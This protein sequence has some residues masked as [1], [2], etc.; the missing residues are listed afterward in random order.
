MIKKTARRCRT[1]AGPYVW[2]GP[3]GHIA[4]LAASFQEAQMT[5]DLKYLVLTAMLTAA[6]WIPYI[7]CQVRPT[8]RSSR[9]IMPI[10]LCRGRC[11]HG[12][13]VRTAP[14]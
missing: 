14:T 13:S 10:L 3:T 12:A 4:R 5:T 6:L 11:P 9:R 2:I 8:A 1:G 7:V